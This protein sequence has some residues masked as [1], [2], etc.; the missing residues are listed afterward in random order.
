MLNTKEQFTPILRV[1]SEK[2]SLIADNP[3]ASGTIFSI[4]MIQAFIKHVLGV[5]ADHSGNIWRYFILLW[6]C[7]QQGRLN[8]T[9]TY[10]VYGLECINTQ[11]IRERIMI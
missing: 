1:S 4:L 9:F 11:E 7:R 5:D 3:V 2:D 6:H 8:F 10:V